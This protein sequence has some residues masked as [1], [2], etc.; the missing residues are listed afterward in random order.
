MIDIKVA[1]MHSIANN[2][3]KDPNQNAIVLCN[4]IQSIFPINNTQWLIVK[5]ILYCVITTT[6]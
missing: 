2:I 1:I 3:T 4:A 6:V 5:A